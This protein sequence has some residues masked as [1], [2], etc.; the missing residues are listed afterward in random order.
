MNVRRETGTVLVL[1]AAVYGLVLDVTGELHRSSRALEFFATL[2]VVQAAAT[3]WRAW[4][5]SRTSSSPPDA[6]PKV[7]TAGSLHHS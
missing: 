1:S 4:R 6:G 2:W 3:L 7:E 5:R